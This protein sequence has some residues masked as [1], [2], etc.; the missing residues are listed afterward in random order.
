MAALEARAKALADAANFVAGSGATF[1]TDLDDAGLR[2]KVIEAVRTAE[3]NIAVIVG[4]DLDD[5]DLREKVIEAVSAAEKGINI[6][7][8]MDVDADGLKERVKAEADAAGAGEKIKVRVESD[9][10][11]LEQD[12][13]SKAGRVKPQ[14]IKVP[15]QSDADKFE[16]ELRASFAEGEKNAAA[17]EKA[18]NQSFTAMQTGVRALRSAMAELEPATQDAEDFETSFRKAMDEGERVSQEADRVLRQSFT[19]MES[20]SRTLRAAMTELQPAAEGAG[21]AA[22]NAGSGFNTS[23]LRMSSLI[24]AALALGPAL[25]AIPA[26][27]GAAGAGFATLG[28]GM[29]GPIA[30]LRDYGAQS[31]ATGQSSAQLAATAFSNA[32]S[33]RNAEQAIADAKRQAAISAINSAQ[34][35]ESAEQGVTDAERQA[36]ISA[37]S[38]ADAVA[39]ADQRLANAQESLTQAQESLTQAQKDGVNVLKDLNLASADAANSVADAQNAVIDAQ[40]AYDKAKGNS[41]LTDQQ[42]KEAQQQLIDAQQHLTDAQQ[43]ALEAQQA[44]NDANQ[45]GV[46]GSTA[47]VAAQRQVVS[48]TQGVADA[49]LAATRAR[50]AQAN[51]EI[52]S[53]QSVA[54]AQQSL[55]TAIRDAA[56]QQISSNES[57][58]KAVQ[59]L[60]DMQEQQALSAAAA[61]SSG[62]AAANKFAQDMAKLTPA[63]RDFVNQLISMRGGLHDLEATA[64]T[65]LLPGFTTLLKDVGGSNGLGSLFNKAVGDMGT[66]IGGT[67]IQFGNLMTSPAFKGQLTQVLKDGAGFAKDLGDG[68]VAL[69]GGLTKAA[70]Q[71]GPIVSGLGG[72]IKTLMSSGIP[73]FFSGLVTNA[74]GAG[75]SIQAIF[76]I[77]SNLAGPLG[78]IAGAFSAALAPAL[79]VLDSPQVQQSLQSIATSIAQILIVLS[80]VVTMLAQGLAGALRIVAPLM[81]SLAKF[82]QDNQQWVVPLAKGIA[83]ATIAFVA[84]NAVLAANPVLLVVA[85][86]AA[87]V[88][89]VVYAYEHF[90]I[91]RDVIHDVWVVTKAEFD[92]FLGFIK[93]WWPELLAPFTG[94]VSEIIA[95]WDAVVD[96][97]KKLPGR[98]VSAGAHMWDWISQ[99]W[100]DDVAAP[101]SKAFDGFI[102]TVTGLPGKLA[103]AGA[104]MWDWIKEEFVGALNAIANLWNQLH[105]S[106]PSFHIPIPFSSGINVDSITVGVPP[107][108][109]FKAAGGPIWGG[110]SAIIGEAGTELLK[111]PTGTQVMP[112]ANTQSMIAQGGLGSSGGVL[113]IEWVGG[114][115]GDELMTWI[116]KNIRIRH[117]SDPNSVQKALGQSF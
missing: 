62:S 60:K 35:I 111:L 102:H 25:A 1:N 87:L 68:L 77:V 66:I 79:Q 110:L 10:T 28:L 53:N 106:T 18:M 44:A 57:V 56:E 83:I 80:P 89:G 61:A 43:K 104:G 19:S 71:A 5:P 31:Q 100:D 54:K 115:G 58:S 8:G 94:G 34:S 76:T 86:I 52:S 95:H 37:Q 81:Q 114:N 33:I 14:P 23:A 97:V 70:S 91:F 90:K 30:A 112:H 65:T 64:Q 12:V 49:Q 11:S 63:G 75:Q 3:R 84:F 85:A 108:G 74:G 93:R 82:I 48:A 41:L 29:A 22:A 101:V 46:D 7:V 69:T 27:V 15:I 107:I 117:G 99:K 98:L 59:A 50:E 55:A 9:G 47:V 42:K 78:T 40:A 51:Q 32:V 103:R 2:D 92:F 45:K 21:Q 73:D 72:G 109:P 88:L 105:F 96:F 13:A 16:A 36:A 17:A 6:I 24:G 4:I 113:Q 67:A 26:V 20:G 116:R 39:S 38:A